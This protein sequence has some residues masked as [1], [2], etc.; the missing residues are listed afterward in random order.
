MT[1]SKRLRYEILR[2]DNHACRYCGRAA[3]EV[4]LTVDH[5]VPVALGGSDDP[6]NLVAACKDCN[7][8]KSASAPDAPLAADVAQDALRW[9]AAIRQASAVQLAEQQRAQEITA[10][11]D[12]LWTE[13]ADVPRPAAWP[14]TITRLVSL[15]LD[16]AVIE[17][18]MLVAMR[19]TQVPASRVW[20]YF[21][22]VCWRRIG[23]LQD[24]ARDVL[25]TE[26]GGVTD[27]S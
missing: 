5:I 27:G 15:G 1:I 10:W 12:T 2:R 11:F 3:P 26:D 25:A 20:R 8:G 13:Y 21:C 18:A 19:N 24:I 6:G 7:S 17:E 14:D 22:G 9:A 4:P 23:E 16:L